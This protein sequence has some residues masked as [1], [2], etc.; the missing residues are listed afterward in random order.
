M[1][2]SYW[3][4]GARFT[5]HASHEDTAGRY[6][7]IEGGGPPG[8]QAPLH[9]HNRYAEQ[10]YVVEGE[11]TVWAGKQTAVLHPGDA[12]TIPAGTAHTVA[13]TGDGPGRVSSPGR[14]PLSRMGRWMAVAAVLLPTVCQTPSGQPIAWKPLSGP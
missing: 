13:V 8:F 4:S 1:R 12:F 3:L 5:V 14:Y 9:R 6:D 2:K 10:L 7:L 11:F